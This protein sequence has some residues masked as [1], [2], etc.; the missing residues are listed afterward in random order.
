M[1]LLLIMIVYSDPDFELD[2]QN[3]YD[4]HELSYFSE[5]DT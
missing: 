3:K 2:K 1:L 5:V 4:N